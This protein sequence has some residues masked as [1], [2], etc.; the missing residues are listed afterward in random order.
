MS[1][2]L[3]NYQVEHTHKLLNVLCKH[4]CALDASDTGTGK[5]Y[6]TI[7]LCEF[8][9]MEPFIICPLSVINVWVRLCEMNKT[10]IFG[11]AN[12]EMIK[13]CKY[14]NYKMEVK[15]CTFL[16]KSENKDFMFNLPRNIIL[17]F[18]EAHKCKN[19]KS[20]ASKLLISAK[21]TN[22]KILLLSATIIDKIKF[23]KP[24]GSM[25][26]LYKNTSDFIKWKNIQIKEKE[27]YFQ[28]TNKDEIILR[29][30][31]NVM[32]PEYG[33]RM[34]K[35][36]LGSQFKNDIIFNCYTLENHD[37]V[38]RL[39]IEINKHLEDLKNREKRGSALTQISIA[40]Q[41]IEMLKVPL[42]MEL[43]LDGIENGCS[44]L[45][46]VN[47]R[48]TMFQLANLLDV[49]C[50]VHGKQTKEERQKS[51]DDFQSN[52]KKIIILII[53][54]GGTGISLHDIIGGHPRLSIVSPCFSGTNLEQSM[55]R[56]DREGKQTD[57]VYK[58]VFI[59]NTYEEKICEIA[60]NKL[61][62]IKLI[63]DG[64]KVDKIIDQK[65]HF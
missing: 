54:S 42:F 57:S 32:F 1:I 7:K 56:T 40:R 10:Q 17:I 4:N 65:D 59:A 55:G 60:K 21:R 53:E 11:I 52:I 44:V 61:N 19:Y 28:C 18:D 45:I 22:N 25:F 31:H 64:K 50:L 34:R 12:Y 33:S 16:G 9:S 30:I 2:I 51:I 8:L 15:E 58:L 62:N 14:Y 20:I 24:F 27:K 6:T 38:H 63:N 29:I 43:C 46:F 47:F 26:G 3:R 13:N 49:D 37:H 41:K 5:T 36:D 35:S 39:Y 48:K 23:F